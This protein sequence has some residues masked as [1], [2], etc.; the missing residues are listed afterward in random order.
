MGMTLLLRIVIVP[1]FTGNFN[2]PCAV[3]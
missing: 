3:D 1:P 2:I